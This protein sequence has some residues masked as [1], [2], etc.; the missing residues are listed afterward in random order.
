MARKI[1]FCDKG[2]RRLFFG[3]SCMLVYEEKG[4]AY[5]P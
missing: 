3:L 2:N 5:R 4:A 1:F